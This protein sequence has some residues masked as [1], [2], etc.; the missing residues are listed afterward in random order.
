MQ[1]NRN[2]DENDPQTTYT[3]FGTNFH[4]LYDKYFPLIRK[5]RK[6]AMDKPFITNG[7]KESIKSR[8][9]LFKIYLDDPSEINKQNW[10]NKR[11]RVVQIL[12]KAEADYYASFIKKHSDNSK[13]LWKRFGNVL[14]KTK[15]N[16]SSFDKLLVNNHYITDQQSIT[17]EF[18][19][20]FCSVGENLTSKIRDTGIDSFKKYL[21]QPL[22]KSFYL[23]IITINEIIVE[24]NNLEQNKSPGHDEFNAKFLK[25]SHAIIAPIL[26]NI[27]N[28]AIKKGEYPDMLKIAKVLPIFK[29]GSKSLVSNYRPISV[30]S[31]IN[32]IFEKL[33]AKRI[34]SFLEKQ[35][36]LYEFQ[37][38]FRTGHS[39]THA[40]IEITDRI[41][42]A[43]NN[44]ELMCGI[45]LDLSKAFDT[46]NHKI[47]LSKLEYYGFRGPVHNLLKS[48]LTDRKQYVKIGNHKSEL[49]QINCGVPQGSVLGPLLFILYINDLHKAC[50]IGNLRIFADDTTVFFKCININDI[51]SKGTQVMTHLNEWFKDN[52][53]TLNSEK[54]NFIIFR[55]RQNKL[56]NLP[57]QINFENACIIRS[58]SAKYLG[59]ILDEHL[60]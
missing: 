30:L 5:S 60:T 11:N 28:L 19:K 9:A 18:N 54:S 8:N 47:L 17:S 32:K 39:T 53:L 20:Y 16:H 2:L 6:Q 26:C 59:V 10:T 44:N 40:L 29:K 36:I 38:G 23:S 50:N 52:K 56:T 31:C 21:N 46:V 27:F 7:I 49:R 22:Q 13:Q 41:K 33:L 3:E 24:I 42:L 51:T 15:S 43:I 34:Y 55:S 25:I 57:D 14:S 48:Y 58:D 12:R 35:N 4:T 1:N 45:F 37:Y